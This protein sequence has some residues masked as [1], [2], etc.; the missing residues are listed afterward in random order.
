MTSSCADRTIREGDKV[1]IWYISA[2]RDELVFDDPY[3]FDVG[4]R[5]NDHVSFGRGGPHFCLGAHL[6]KLEVKVMFEELL[7][8]LAAIE[9]AGPAERIRTNFTNAFKSMP[10]RSSAS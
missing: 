4:R 2:N 8:R 9:P 1:V 10:V 7:P 5:P 3:R 6:A